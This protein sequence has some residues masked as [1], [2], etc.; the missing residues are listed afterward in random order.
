MGDLREVT[1][2]DGPTMTGIVNR[3]IKMGYVE[4]TRSEIDRRV[5]L[6]Q[7]TPTSI[8]LVNRIEE[9]ALKDDLCG[10]A[11]LTDDDLVALEQLLTYILRMYMRRY[12]DA[13]NTDFEEALKKLKLFKNDPICYAKNSLREVL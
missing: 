7:A 6:V 9:D 5:V 1:F 13:Q 10:Y 4:R 8:D 3:L 12:T 11:A 2:Q